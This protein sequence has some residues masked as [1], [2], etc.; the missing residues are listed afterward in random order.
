MQQLKNQISP[1]ST[2][3]KRVDRIN[4]PPPL[5][6]GLKHPFKSKLKCF[7][8][9]AYGSYSFSLSVIDPLGIL[10]LNVPKYVTRVFSRESLF[11]FHS[12]KKKSKTRESNK[13]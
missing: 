5:K 2:S 9:S 7:L 8:V 3:K 13:I 11:I 6:L 4:P 10:C 1:V 12:E